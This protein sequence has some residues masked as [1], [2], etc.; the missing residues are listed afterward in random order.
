MITKPRR[1]LVVAPSHALELLRGVRP[2]DD[3]VDRWPGCSAAAAAGG[4]Q[5]SPPYGSRALVLR[6]GMG[7]AAAARPS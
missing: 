5:D 3:A 4:I 6:P 7:D 1:V 2:V